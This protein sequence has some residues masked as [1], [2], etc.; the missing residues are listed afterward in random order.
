ME[1]YR[2]GAVLMKATGIHEYT[3]DCRI[4]GALLARV[5][6]IFVLY[7]VLTIF[8]V[9]FSLVLSSIPLF[10]ILSVILV[11]VFFITKPLLSEKRDYE[12][13]DGSFRIYKVYGRSISKKVFELDLKDMTEIAPYSIKKGID[14]KYDTLKDYISDSRS[15]DLYYALFEKNSFRTVILFDGDD[16]FRCAAAFYARRAFRQY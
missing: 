13:V 7:T 3:R 2:I 4:E 16:K 10:V 6:F 14:F 11:S 9:F 15:T 1:Y 8:V 12:I 5:V